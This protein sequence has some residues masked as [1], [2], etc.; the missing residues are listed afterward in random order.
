MKE[1]WKKKESL[2]TTLNKRGTPLGDSSGM[3][4]MEHKTENKEPE[5]PLPLS[6]LL[7]SAMNL[8]SP[9]LQ[10][11]FCFS[12]YM[13]ATDY[14]LYMLYIQPIKEGLILFFQS[15]FQII[16][17]RIDLTIWFIYP[18]FNK[19]VTVIKWGSCCTNL[20]APSDP[21]RW[22]EHYLFPKRKQSSIS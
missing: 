21:C 6:L 12:V 15:Q 8:R 17:K 19:S 14:W 20:V 9:S 18:P 10:P 16:T 13:A 3:S 2:G 4:L 5:N 1:R 7:L 11:V 22:R